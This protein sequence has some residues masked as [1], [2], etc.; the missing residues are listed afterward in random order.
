MKIRFLGA[1]RRVTGSNY[2]VEAAGKKFLVD[3]GLNQGSLEDELFNDVP[4][5]YDV[6]DIDFMLLT[7]AHIDHSGRIP[8]LYKDGFRA[9]IYATKATCDLC[10]IMLPDSGYIQETENEIKNKKR[11]RLGKKPI[12][13]PLYTA[14]DAKKCMEVFKS[15]KYDE[16]IDIEPSIQVRFNDAGHM[17]GSA[18]IE[19]WVTENDKMQKIVFSG[20][21]GNN[22]IPLLSQ[23]TMID[24][25]DYLIMES[26]YG[27][28]LHIKNDQKASLFLDIFYETL[29]KGGTVVIPSFAVGRTQEILYELN[30]LRDQHLDDEE[31]QRKYRML[32]EVP[33]YV[34]SPLAVSATEVFKKNMDLFSDEIKVEIESGDNPLDFDGL[35][36][37]RSVED[38]KAL[39]ESKEPCIIISASGMCDVGRIKH[40][41]KHHLWNYIDTILF[42]GYQAPGTLGK[43][44]VDGDK[45]VKVLGENISVEARVEYIEGYSGHA[46]QEGLLDFVYSFRNKRPKMIFLIHGEPE[47]QYVLKEK[48]LATVDDV[49]VCIPKYGEAYELDGDKS[50]C[51]DVI[52]NPMDKQINRI[53]LIEKM[54]FLEK[55]LV[56]MENQLRF[57][58]DDSINSDD[59]MS[60]LNNRVNDLRKQIIELM[61]K[62]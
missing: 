4:F 60:K 24:D 12:L 26:T 54:Q 15:V 18:I 32:M 3:C 11:K 13:E 25:A 44:I 20:D 1:T 9:P 2:L 56:D 31:F 61:N 34:D 22:D 21:L 30:K 10:E 33:V 14:E 55:E 29:A 5:A 19:I 38:S 43:R 46:D 16:I 7:H 48:I 51:F 17:L 39:N 62:G 36:F 49:N 53:E 6:E 59:S 8:K 58:I 57:N 45:E 42:V 28:R 52:D 40:H 47:A 27:N 35:K 41:L 50:E 23:P 37:T